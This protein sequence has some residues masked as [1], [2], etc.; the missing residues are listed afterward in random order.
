MVSDV[1]LLPVTSRLWNTTLDLSRMSLLRLSGL[2]LFLFLVVG[3][4]LSS[5]PESSVT[6]TSALTALSEVSARCD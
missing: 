6:A 4:R 2:F 1:S 5:F 3:C